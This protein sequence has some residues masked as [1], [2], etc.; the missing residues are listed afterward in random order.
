MSVEQIADSMLPMG[1]LQSSHEVNVIES[2]RAVEFG[3]KIVMIPATRSAEFNV[4][5]TAME[6][7]ATIPR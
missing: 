3:Y 2:M 5:E 6:D 7:G 1:D 4:T